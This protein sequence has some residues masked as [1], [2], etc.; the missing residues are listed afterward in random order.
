VLGVTVLYCFY[1]YYFPPRKENEQ[2]KNIII[3]FSKYPEYLAEAF[4]VSIVGFWGGAQVINLIY[5]L[6]DIFLRK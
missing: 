1:R 2:A 3:K 5:Y 4:L 6:K